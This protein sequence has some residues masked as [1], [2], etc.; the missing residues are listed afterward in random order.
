[1]EVWKKTHLCND[2]EISNYGRVKSL[3]RGSTK[4]L[5]I[6]LNTKGYCHVCLSVDNKQKV[7]TIHRLVA[8]AFILNKYKYPQINHKDGNKLNNNVSNLEW[9]NNKMNQIHALCNGL[10]NV[11]LNI[12]SVIIIKNY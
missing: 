4:I 6:N 7:I 12:E 8:E 5:N 9:C 3:K 1:M 11:K 10:Q 2:Y